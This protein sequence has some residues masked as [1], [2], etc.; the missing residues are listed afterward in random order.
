MAHRHAPEVV[1]QSGAPAS[2]WSPGSGGRGQ[3]VAA[4]NWKCHRLWLRNRPPSGAA[5]EG[6]REKPRRHNVF[7]AVLLGWAFLGFGTLTP[8]RFLCLTDTTPLVPLSGLRG[9]VAPP[10]STAASSQTLDSVSHVPAWGCGA[11]GGSVEVE[12]CPVWDGWP[13][14]GRVWTVS[15]T[16]EGRQVF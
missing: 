13:A 8:S 4:H 5:G 11:V 3:E 2:A 1:E 14:P 7:S 9:R 15:G 6:K 10:Q 16:G 12:S